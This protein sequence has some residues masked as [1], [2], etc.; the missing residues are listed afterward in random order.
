MM[1][2]M[3][4]LGK[5]ICSDRFKILS[6]AAIS[7]FLASTIALADG[8]LEDAGDAISQGNYAQ[9]YCMLKPLAEGNNHQAQYQLG[10]MYHNGYGLAVDDERAKQWWQ[11]AAKGGVSSA[12]I[13][14]VMLY[15]EGG[16]GVKKNLSLAAKHLVMAASSGDEESRL[17]LSHYIDDSEWQLKKRL[18]KILREQPDRLGDPVSVKK[19]GVNLR[20]RASSQ[21]KVLE[22]VKKDEKLLRVSQ[23]GN[24][25]HVIQLRKRR[26]AWIHHQLIE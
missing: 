3:S 13:A 9:A 11:K 4:N 18:R 2:A 20:S 19:D 16:V 10:W 8:T 22:S 6:G 12:Q 26:F 21:S 7:F 24:W 1:S 23:K 25:V 14:L 5:R 17:L 15:R